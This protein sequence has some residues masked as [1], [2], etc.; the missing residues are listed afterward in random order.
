MNTEWYLESV[1]PDCNR[2]RWYRLCADWTLFGGRIVSEWG[3][4]GRKGGRRVKECS[5]YR[6]AMREVNRILR[7]RERHG[8]RRIS[9]EATC[10]STRQRERS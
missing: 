7:L 1:D 4:I 2:Q 9:D 3:R 8:Y 10:G 6:E 5:T